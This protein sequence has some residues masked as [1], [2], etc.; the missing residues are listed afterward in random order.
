MTVVETL[1][2]WVCATR[3]DDVPERVRELTRAQVA[4]VIAAIFASAH[5]RDA[6]A[7]HRAVQGWAAPGPASVLGSGER[8]AIHDAVLVNSARSMALDYDDYL[9]MGHTGHSAVL[10]GLALGEAEGHAPK[11]VLSA[12]V[13]ANEIG[14]RVGASAVL[15]PQ[16]GQAWS[17]IHAI[18]GAVVGSKLWRLSRAQTAHALAIA[19]YQPTFTLWPGFMG[20]GSKVLTAAH[21]TVVGLQAAAFAREGMTG[22][23]EIFEH[24]R[25]G[26]WA[27]FSWAPLPKMLSRLGE[28]W[29]SDTLA[30]KRYPGCAYIDTTLDALF[31]VLDEVRAETGGALRA[32]DVKRVV[33]DAS[34]LSVE[35]DNL[36][37]EHVRADEPLSPVNVNFSIPFN[38]AIAIALGAH[39]GRAL[40]QG[41]LDAHAAVIRELAAKTELRHDWGMTLAV[42]RAFDGVAGG[43]LKELRPGQ[44]AGLFAGYKKQ[45]GGK[46]RTGL[47]AR[48]LLGEWGTLAKMAGSSR[49]RAPRD[50]TGFRMVFPARVSI[51]L[52]DGR[53]YRARQDVPV[54][55]PGQPGRVEAAYEKLAREAHLPA[56][57]ARAL[58]AALRDFEARPVAETVRL[59]CPG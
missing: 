42:V 25:K 50:F 3:Y 44:L 33:V 45:L 14:G 56:D 8:W 37:S 23:R 11:D 58:A 29:V 35:M 5:S 21:P 31:M 24:R 32:E 28:G 26:F 6:G 34:L 20:P 48:G 38:V 16:N 12:M 18:E 52:Q 51:E 22:A 57:R 19:L 49:G 55:A 30:F 1:A 53:R 4:S 47:R 46:K 7:V 10:A 27:S 13:L 54:G 15:G 40:S 9:Y 2:D 39:H 17:F 59:A 43:T 36:S 41:T